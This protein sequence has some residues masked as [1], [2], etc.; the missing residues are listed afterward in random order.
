M[1]GR[2]QIALLPYYRLKTK[3]ENQGFSQ[4][5]SG[6][7]GYWNPLCSATIRC[8]SHKGIAFLFKMVSFILSVLVTG[9]FDCNAYTEFIYL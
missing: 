4:E 9:A 8:L 2:K 6:R 1:G 3:E 7:I 5:V